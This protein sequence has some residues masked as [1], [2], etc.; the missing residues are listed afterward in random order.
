MY[1]KRQWVSLWDKRTNEV[2]IFENERRELTLK[3]DDGVA[4]TGEMIKAWVDA[5]TCR[6]KVSYRIN[7]E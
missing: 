3:I 6:P 2:T 4:P 5:W 7:V 1:Y